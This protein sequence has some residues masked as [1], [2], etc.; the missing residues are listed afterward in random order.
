M[1]GCYGNSAED[2]YFENK[3]MD[4]LD[5]TEPYCT[6]CGTQTEELENELCEDCFKDSEE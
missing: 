6:N 5:D 3:L 1:A 4:Y 2:R